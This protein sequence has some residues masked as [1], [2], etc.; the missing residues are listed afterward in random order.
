MNTQVLPQEAD[1]IIYAVPR[2]SQT[3]QKLQ[4]MNEQ[5]YSSFIRVLFGLSSPSP[6]PENL[7]TAPDAEKMEWI[8]PDLN[9]SQKEAIRFALA[10]REIAL[11]HGPPG[12]RRILVQ[13]C[14]GRACHHVTDGHHR[15]ERR[16][17]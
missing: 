8:S 9:D 10:S 15:P 12:V 6:I 11:I 14:T 1:A 7:S 4:K 16:T 2:M 3:M 5:E 13:T 17:L